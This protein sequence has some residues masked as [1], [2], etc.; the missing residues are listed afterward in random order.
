MVEC[1]LKKQFPSSRSKAYEIRFG[2]SKFLADGEEYTRMFVCN[3]MALVAEHLKAGFQFTFSA[4]DE[5]QGVCNLSYMVFTDEKEAV[6]RVVK[7][8]FSSAAVPGGK[9]KISNANFYKDPFL[10]EPADF[11]AVIQEIAN[12]VRPLDVANT[13]SISLT[14]PMLDRYIKAV[15]SA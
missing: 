13:R 5:P 8:L 3:T 10:S 1:W 11:T 4:G 6:L 15:V 12:L 2:S 7:S 9:W 14:H